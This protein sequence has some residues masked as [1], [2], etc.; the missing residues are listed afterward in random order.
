MGPIYILVVFKYCS[1]AVTIPWARSS[2]LWVPAGAKMTFLQN[3]R[4]ILGP[5]MLPTQRIPEALFPGITRCPNVMTFHLHLAPR[6]RMSGAMPPL[7]IY[8]LMACIGAKIDIY[9]YPIY[10][11]IYIYIY[12]RGLLEKYPTFGREKETGLPGALDT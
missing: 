5:A 3:S 1:Y 8:A 7:D 11:Y 12:I 9:L 6:F 10:I 4:S 2:G